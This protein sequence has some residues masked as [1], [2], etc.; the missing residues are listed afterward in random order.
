[1]TT[2]EENSLDDDHE[3]AEVLTKIT[4]LPRVLTMMTRSRGTHDNAAR[5]GE[6]LD[7]TLQVQGSLDNDDRPEG[8]MTMLQCRES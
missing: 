5:C 7:T 8:L 3:G 6:S 4:N 1:M 2:T